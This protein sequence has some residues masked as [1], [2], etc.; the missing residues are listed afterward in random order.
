MNERK[1]PAIV[2]ILDSDYTAALALMAPFIFWLLFWML[3]IMHIVDMQIPRYLAIALTLA[4]LLL[5]AWRCW[6]ISQIFV[7]GVDTQ[8]EVQHVWFSGDRGRLVFTFIWGRAPL[9][10][11]SLIPKNEYTKSLREGQAIM[12]MVDPHHPKRA[13]VCDLYLRPPLQK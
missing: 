11:N 13:F 2:R 8:A 3:S 6:L 9:Q 4:S 1:R 12:V 5:M 7:N 10:K